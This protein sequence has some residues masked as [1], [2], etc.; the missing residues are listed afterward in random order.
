MSKSVH[1]EIPRD[2]GVTEPVNDR[3]KRNSASCVKTEH[4]TLHCRGW[5]DVL[6]CR[7]AA[8]TRKKL[9]CDLKSVPGG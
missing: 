7:V 4:K 1:N 8:E 2:N 5:K 3:T 6:F 9:R